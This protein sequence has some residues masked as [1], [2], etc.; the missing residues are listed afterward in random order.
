MSLR[1]LARQLSTVVAGGLAAT[2][3]ALAPAPAGAATNPAVAAPAA[4]ASGWKA[5]PAQYTATT[6]VKDLAIPMS[7]GVSSAAT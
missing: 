1:P 2:T 6:S 4:T 5:R 3:L 7:D